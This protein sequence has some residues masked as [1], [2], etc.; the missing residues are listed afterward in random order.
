MERV[1]STPQFSHQAVDLFDREKEF[2]SIDDSTVPSPKQVLF[3]P[4]SPGSSVSCERGQSSTDEDESLESSDVESVLS[5]A[6]TKSLSGTDSFS[7]LSPRSSTPFPVSADVTSKTTS[8]PGHTQQIGAVFQDLDN[9]PE[10]NVSFSGAALCGFYFNGICQQL[11]ARRVRIGKA[12]GA[13]AGALSALSLLLGSPPE[14]HEEILHLYDQQR[15]STPWILLK[16]RGGSTLRRS[17]WNCTWANMDVDMMLPDFTWESEIVNK[18]LLPI[19][20]P[21]KCRDR[22][23]REING[24]LHVAVTRVCGYDRDSKRWQHPT[25]HPTHFLRDVRY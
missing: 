13:S 4:K 9:V 18:I 7:L 21:A 2:E 8:Y 16:A 5:S 19:D 25:C 1:F 23:E 12:Y 17:V 10:I 3:R 15:E 24:K 6:L 14:C 20:D 22:I 11:V